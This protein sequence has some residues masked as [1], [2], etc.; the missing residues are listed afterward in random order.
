MQGIRIAGLAAAL[1]LIAVTPARAA[2]LPDL[3][4]GIEPS[5]AATQPALTTTITFFAGDSALERF[6]LTLPAGFEPAGAPGATACAPM[7]LAAGRCGAG[8]RIGT[9]DGRIGNAIGVSG[10]IHK[11]SGDRFAAVVSTLGGAVGQIV[12]GSI[13]KRANGSLDLKLDQ[14]PALPLTSLSFR[15]DG[16]PRSLVTTPAACGEYGVDGKFTSRTGELAL[17]RTKVAVTG[18]TGIPAVQVANIRMNQTRL[19]AGRGYSTIIAW[20]ASRAADHTN[21][22]I[23]RRV[24]G[25]WRVVGVLVTNASPGDNYVRWDGRLRERALKPGAYAVRIQP[26]GSAPSPKRLRFRVV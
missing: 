9:V 24:R 8:S 21:V 7:A 19:H 3:T 4:L 2:F 17:D 23:E 6:T 15:F 11:L 14:L 20:W 5:T 1:C 16:G 13:A 26:A 12:P 18:C 22:R 25:H 10:S